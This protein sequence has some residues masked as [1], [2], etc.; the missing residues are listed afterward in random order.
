MS[1]KSPRSIITS[2]SCRPRFAQ[3]AASHVAS[4][5]PVINIAK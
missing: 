4:A 5:K 2:W 1:E 3:R